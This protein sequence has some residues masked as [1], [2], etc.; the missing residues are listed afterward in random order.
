MTC[1]VNEPAVFNDSLSPERMR[2]GEVIV[3]CLRLVHRLAAD[4]ALSLGALVNY[5]LVCFVEEP[6][7][8]E[9][10]KEIHGE[11][12]RAQRAGHEGAGRC[13]GHG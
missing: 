8:I 1:G 2:E 12:D 3:F 13:H 7:R 10:S 11:G 9:P 5:L 4:A 6:L